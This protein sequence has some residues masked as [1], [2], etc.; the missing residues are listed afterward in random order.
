MGD[1]LRNNVK[2]WPSYFVAALFWAGEYKLFM[3]ED[4][5][6][7]IFAFQYSELSGIFSP[8]YGNSFSFSPKACCRGMTTGL[9][10]TFAALYP[11]CCRGTVLYSRG[12]V[13][14]FVSE[15]F[16]DKNDTLSL[17]R[18]LAH[19][20]DRGLLLFSTVISWDL[21]QMWLVLTRD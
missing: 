13:R 17:S 15:H 5:F 2:L 10:W 9:T 7:E 21:N 12:S 11:P 14:I 16:K 6:F 1:L 18:I 8:R 19:H 4:S 20:L 3:T